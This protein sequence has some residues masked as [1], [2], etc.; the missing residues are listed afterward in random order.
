M[1]FVEKKTACVFRW[2][3]SKRTNKGPILK[4]TP[5]SMCVVGQSPTM[6]NGGLFQHLSGENNIEALCSVEWCAKARNFFSLNS[7]GEQPLM[8][9]S[10]ALEIAYNEVHV[11]VRS[12]KG[13]Y[14]N[15]F[16]FDFN[17]IRYFSVN[18]TLSD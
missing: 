4:S 3:L 13:K 14:M 17:T 9:I 7:A 11:L 2:V 5:M 6:E 18:P 10:A 15:I 8:D 1:N 12:V 16:D